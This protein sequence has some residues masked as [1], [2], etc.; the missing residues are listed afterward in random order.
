MLY[1]VLVSNDWHIPLHDPRACQLVIDI[2]Q[3]LNVEYFII[4]GDLTDFYLLNSHNPKDPE[5]KFTFEDEIAQTNEWLDKMQK[6]LPNTKIHYIM[7]NHEYRLDRFVRDKCPVFWNLLSVKNELRLAQR[8]IT[9]TPYNE[10]CRIEGTDL[11]IQHS[12]PS[13]GE[14][15]ARTGLLKKPS[16][17]WIW[18]CTHRMQQA[19]ITDAQGIVRSSYF[20]GWLGSTTLT[21]QHKAVFKYTKNHENWQQGFSIVTVVGND[22]F[23]NQYQI[24][25]NRVVIGSNVYEG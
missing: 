1:Q 13:Y 3:D 23:V 7:G 24:K 4:N 10:A 19:H 9:W 12:P 15:G 20:N 6:A 16:A 22:T 18:G 17:S 2:A 14:N 25:D 21:D 11:F 5:V 8:N